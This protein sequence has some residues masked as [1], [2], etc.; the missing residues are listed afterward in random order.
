MLIGLLFAFYLFI[1][2]FNLFLKGQQDNNSREEHL[3]LIEV[4]KTQGLGT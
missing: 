4:G 2:V 3:D 1:F